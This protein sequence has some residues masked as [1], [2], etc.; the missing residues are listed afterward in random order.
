MIKSAIHNAIDFSSSLNRSGSGYDP[1]LQ[2]SVN[3]ISFYGEFLCFG[4][5]PDV[6]PEATPDATLTSYLRSSPGAVETNTQDHVIEIDGTYI[7]FFDI[8]KI[9]LIAGVWDFS[10]Q[11]ENEIIYSEKCEAIM[12]EDF[13]ERNILKV[14]A[15]NEDF[16]YGFLDEDYP[17]CGF[18]EV[19]DLNDKPLAVEKVEFKYSFN[20]SKILRSESVVKRRLTFVNL[21]VYQQNLLKFLC[22]CQHLELNGVHYQL[23]SDFVERNKDENNEVCDLQAEFIAADQTYFDFSAIEKPRDLTIKNLF[24]V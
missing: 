18:F 11:I 23:V 21:S 1:D 10:M 6:A 17:A 7:Y 14:K 24:N 12:A 19:S 8:S 2:R 15:Y 13:H 4:Y 20:R 5:T 16:R 9:G 22:N 3:I